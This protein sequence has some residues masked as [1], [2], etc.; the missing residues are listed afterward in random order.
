MPRERIITIVQLRDYLDVVIRGERGELIDVTGIP[1][2]WYTEQRE[3]T[4]VRSSSNR[5]H[6]RILT[7]EAKCRLLLDEGGANYDGA[8]VNPATV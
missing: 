1:P 5:H 3:R 2:K 7:T 4:E 6:N 8:A